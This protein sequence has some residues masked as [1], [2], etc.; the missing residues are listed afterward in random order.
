MIEEYEFGRIVIDG[1]EY[2][3][4]VIV[5]PDGVDD[6]W[7]RNEGHRLCLEDL[8]DVFAARPE[9]LVVG[10]GASGRMQVPADVQEAVTGCGIEMRVARTAEATK[11]YNELA[12]TR[13][14][15]AALHLT[16]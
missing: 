7:W 8:E 3:A 15:V 2:T 11:L 14:T 16:C 9:V 5:T 12:P 1:D 6:S 4:D 10:T 13:R